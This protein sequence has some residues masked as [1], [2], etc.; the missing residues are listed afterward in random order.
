MSVVSYIIISIANVNQSTVLIMTL[1][2]NN[3][4]LMRMLV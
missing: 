3:T 2:A 1:A 4:V